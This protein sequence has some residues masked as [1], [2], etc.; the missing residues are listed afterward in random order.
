MLLL[1]SCTAAFL[2]DETLS[3]V[4]SC[5]HDAQGYMASGWPDRQNLVQLMFDARPGLR[6]RLGVAAACERGRLMLRAGAKRLYHRA[7]A[8]RRR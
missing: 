6:L 1:E 4:D 3:F 5:C 2:A 8:M 7:R